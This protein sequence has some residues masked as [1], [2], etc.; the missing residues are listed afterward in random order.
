MGKFT[1]T[2]DMSSIDSPTVAASEVSGALRAVAS[3][4][5]KYGV[6]DGDDRPLFTTKGVRLGGWKYEEES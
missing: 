5:D 1:V 2:L 6:D 4:I 3:W